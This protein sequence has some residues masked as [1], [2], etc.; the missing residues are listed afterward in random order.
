[1]SPSDILAIEKK[2]Q[3]RWSSQKAAFVDTTAP[4]SRGT[5]LLVMLPYP[6][7]DRLH[8]GHARTYFL[9][10]ALHRFY[11]QRGRNIL[12]PMGWDAFG[13]PAEN[14]AIERGIHPREST[15]ANIAAMKEQFQNWGVLYDW[16]KEVTTCEPEYYRWNQW[17]FLKMLE[18]GLAVRKK[19]PVNWCPSCETVLA[20]EQAEGG[21]CERCKNRVVQKELE[22]WFLTITKYADSLLSG[23]DSLDKWPEKVRVMQKNW[24][25]RSV[26][27]DLKFDLPSL[28]ESLWVFTTRPDTVFGVTALFVAPEHPMVPRLIE[29][30]PD[31]A[32]IEAWVSKVRN[33]DRIEREAETTEKEGRDTGIRA[34]HPFTGAEIP[35][36]I[37][38]FVI[39]DYGTGALM[40]VPAHDDRDF[41]F[42]TKYSLPIVEV[43]RRPAS[44]E[45]SIA[46]W[47]GEGTMVNSGRFDGLTSEAGREAIANEA[48]S[49]GFGGPQ[50][51]YRLRDWLI[52]RQRYWGTPIPVVYC[53][54]CSWVPVP[55]SHLPVV[56][57]KDAPFTG[58]GGNPLTKVESFVKTP[59]PKCGGPARRETDT[60]D[61]F[62][63]SSWYF[64]RY[65]DPE[66]SARPFDGDV[67]RRWMPVT[68]YIGGIE[69]AI[70]H[71]LYARFFSRVLKDLGLVE[72]EEPFAALF[73]QG[74]ITRMSPSG[75][76]EKMSKSRGNAV[77]LDPLIAEKGADTVR[78]YVLFLGP[79]EAEAVWSDE[80][81][82]GAERFLTRVRSVAARFLDG[83][84]DPAARPA[85]ADTPAARR[86]HKTVRLVTASFERFSFHTAVAH[87]MEFAREVADLLAD[88]VA[89]PG[90]KATSLR[91]LIALLHPV[92]PHLAEELHERMGGTQSLLSG[93]WP[94]FDPALA[95]E[96]TVVF[97]VQVN[98]KLRG[99]LTL[100]KAA[101]E[102]E[103]LAAAEAHEP[104]ARWLA[105]KERVKTIFV[106]GRLLN[107]VV[108]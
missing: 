78:T 73:N 20:N 74:M 18:K 44:A 49:G 45:S 41:A 93:S 22:Q 26:G 72:V 58:K 32:G 47:T 62:V 11:R 39:A 5:Y 28:G 89:D 31:R 86:R 64:L 24:I 108:R 91:T 42:C 55:E 69:H 105:G 104:V 99:Q 85:V 68:Q 8:V 2:W 16:S 21:V 83:G 6:S 3:D 84:T 57:P 103:V 50:V 80:G 95:E 15:L 87:L 98:G 106:P 97:A 61:T 10:D 13:L 35:V 96:D 30:H 66:N 4:D 102:G 29:N 46:C 82:A 27:A 79:A 23:L 88:P 12:C 19:A 67:A 1:M 60:M 51:R 43:I 75:R 17:F 76:I 53:D 38:N 107:L 70:L 25:G 65:L 56:L 54:T 14:Y 52:S 59:C 101:A 71:L 33:S 36:W 7:G 48:A 81:I 40:A 37:A 92:A 100:P 77:S 9:T 90:E 94:E 63:D 34:R